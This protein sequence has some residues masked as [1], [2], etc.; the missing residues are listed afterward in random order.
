MTGQS[1]KKEQLGTP[2]KNVSKPLLFLILICQR[3]RRYREERLE[4]EKTTF[5]QSEARLSKFR[6]ARQ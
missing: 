5:F 6:I 2:D 4:K 1:Q 3:P